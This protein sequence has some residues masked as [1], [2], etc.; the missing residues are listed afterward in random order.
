MEMTKENFK[1]FRKDLKTAVAEL[2]K[3]YGIVIGTGGSI[4]YTDNSFSMKLTVTNGTDASEAEKIEFANNIYAVASYGLTE[5]D[6]G[7]KFTN[8]KGKFVLVGIKPR[9]R[10]NPLIIR[11]ENGTQ[12]VCAP[13]FL[14]LRPVA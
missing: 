11:D 14:G 13:A 4:S 9:S 10:K 12:Y 8:A 7:R 3:K 6:Y 1:A 5:K 2:E